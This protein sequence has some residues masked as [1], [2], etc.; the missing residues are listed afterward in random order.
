[1]GLPYTCAPTN[2]TIEQ[3]HARPVYLAEVRNEEEIMSEGREVL[4]RELDRGLSD[5]G[6][7]V[8]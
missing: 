6:I 4:R 7:L 2:D 1:M 3:S 5:G 8:D